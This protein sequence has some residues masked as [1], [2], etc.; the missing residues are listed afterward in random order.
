M[1]AKTGRKVCELIAGI[2]ATD[3]ELHPAELQF[4]LRTFDTFGVARGDE[5]EALSPTVRA[6]EAERQM[7]ELPDA[8][9][10]ETLALLIS[11]AVV[12]GKVTPAEHDWLLAVGRAAGIPGEAI[13]ERIAK[14]LL[15]AESGA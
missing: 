8:V 10:E 7:G 6:I 13:E 11:S 2:I 12:D 4:M 14:A 3:K 5:D 15:E 9:R 1:D